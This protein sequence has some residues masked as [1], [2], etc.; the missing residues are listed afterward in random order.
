MKAS[1]SL[2]SLQASAETPDKGVK[3]RACN[4]LNKKKRREE[5]WRRSW[6]STGGGSTVSD[7]KDDFWS[8]LQ[9]NYD[10]IM[11][12]QLIDNCQVNIYIFFPFSPTACKFVQTRKSKFLGQVNLLKLKI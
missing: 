5:Y 1:F 10:Y 3:I 8:A 12:N 11:D 9:A 4:S 6:G 7:Q 2:S